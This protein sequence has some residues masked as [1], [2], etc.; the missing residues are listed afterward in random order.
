[1]NAY[2]DTYG[3]LTIVADTETETYAL[4]NWVKQAEEK[5]NASGEVVL[6]NMTSINSQKYLGR[7]ADIKKA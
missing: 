1:M 6:A 4:N 2:I 3:R 5:K 7:L